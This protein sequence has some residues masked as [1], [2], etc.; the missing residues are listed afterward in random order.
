MGKKDAKERKEKVH[1]EA[2]LKQE[3]KAT[4]RYARKMREQANKEIMKKSRIFERRKKLK[5]REVKLNK[6]ESERQR[7]QKEAKERGTKVGMCKERRVKGKFITY[8]YAREAA[9]TSAV[10]AAQK[11]GKDVA[12]N[13]MLRVQNGLGNLKQHSDIKFSAKGN[14]II[15][16][17]SETELGESGQFIFG[18][19]KSAFFRNSMLKVKANEL[20]TKGN[21]GQYVARRRYV[22]RRRRWAAPKITAA[23]RRSVLSSRRRA[24]VER[25]RRSTQVLESAVTSAVLKV[26]KFG[27]PSAK[28]TVKATKCSWHRATISYATAATLATPVSWAEDA[29]MVAL[30]E[31]ESANLSAEDTVQKG[32]WKKKIKVAPKGT[33]YNRRRRA[34]VPRK[35]LPSIP[36]AKPFVPSR[37]RYI[38]RR[39]RLPMPTKKSA[40]PPT[41]GTPNPTARRRR[42]VGKTT[43]TVFAPASNNVWV[44]IKL[45]PNIV[46]VMRSKDKMCF[47]ITGGG[48][49]QPVIL[50][51]EKSTNK[52]HLVLNVKGQGE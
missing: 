16:E 50:G 26:Y 43:G 31:G 12:Y 7:A 36:Y 30:Q 32:Y 11:F 18:K 35:A 52:P 51:S 19:K 20:I 46:G 15:D 25:R 21:R 49:V 8:A 23:R 14:K 1:H 17:A 44:S 42:F 48:P 28:L 6:A 29:S 24:V 40:K 33:D 13:G 27:G 47:E 4:I 41:S 9:F 37:R 22:D 3:Q 34:P 38:D 2:R 45:S 39:R 5:E 10:S